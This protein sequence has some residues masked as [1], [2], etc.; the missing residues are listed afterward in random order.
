M[1]QHPTKSPSL[2][3][4]DEVVKDILE[5]MSIDDKARV[6]HTDK[7]ELFM[8]HHGWGTYLR[9]YYQMWHNKDLVKSTGKEH[10]DDASMV[11]IEEV[12][13]ILQESD[14]PG[15]EAPPEPP[16]IGK[17]VFFKWHVEKSCLEI[18]CSRASLVI[19]QIDLDFAKAIATGMKANLIQMRTPY[20]HPDDVQRETYQTPGASVTLRKYPKYKED[21]EVKRDV[22]VEWQINGQ[23]LAISCGG[24][25]IAIEFIDLDLAEAVANAMQVGL[26]EV[27]SYTAADVAPKIT[28]GKL[29]VT[30]KLWEYS[31]FGQQY[32]TER[33]T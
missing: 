1:N 32:R 28:H 8:F 19:E 6:K 2:H 24:H 10:P 22:Y 11:I 31:T 9:N 3:A 23:Y 14:E 15:L 21:G 26:P 13:T 12:W 27:E 30:V 17:N 5:N 18:A 20:L 7:D 29:G 25:I 4:K 16:E 33:T